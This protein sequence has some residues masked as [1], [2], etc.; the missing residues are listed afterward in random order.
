MSEVNIFNEELDEFEFEK[1]SIFFDKKRKTWFLESNDEVLNLVLNSEVIESN[2]KELNSIDFKQE[3][4][5]DLKKFKEVSNENS[6]V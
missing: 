1:F 5:N 4:L 3:Y 6:R 2:K